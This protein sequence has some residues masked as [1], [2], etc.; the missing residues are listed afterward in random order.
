MDK[1]QSFQKEVKY[2]ERQA[3]RSTET[4]PL[5]H[6]VAQVVWNQTGCWVEIG[7]ETYFHIELSLAQRIDW[8]SYG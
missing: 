5:S 1:E 4:P 7:K 2:T 3:H 8:K 6:I